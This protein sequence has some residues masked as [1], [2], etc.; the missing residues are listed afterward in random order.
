MSGR[1]SL[2]RQLPGVLV[3]LAVESRGQPAYRLALQTREQYI[4]REKATSNLCTAQVLLAVI[5]SMYAVYHG[6]EGLT[7]I[8]RTVHRRA[9]VLAAGLR[10]LGFALKSEAFFDT[11]TVDVGARKSEIV[12]RAHAEEINLRIGEGTLG[13]ALDETTTP[14]TVEAVWHA[15]GGKLSYAET[16]V[17]ARETLPAALKRDSAFLTHPVFHTH[18]SETELLRYMRKLSDRD[19]ALDR[20]MIPLGSCTMKLN[21]T[22]EMIPLTW[23][24]FGS[25]HPFAPREQ[26]EGYHA[27]FKR[28]EQWL[29][30][31]T[32][33]DAISLQPNSGAQG[34]YA[35]LLAIRA[36]HAARGEPHR[37]VCPIPS[38]AHGTNPASAVMAGMEVVVVGCDARGDVDVDDLRA[39]AEKHSRNLAA[40]MITYPSTHGV[41]A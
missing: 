21:A 4:R 5:A 38:S 22:A 18:R 3:W 16:E 19:L 30:D 35:G 40:V 15:F 29:C 41:F 31:I 37:K 36:Y 39:K 10:K 7:H 33:Y 8:A 24:E 27:L 11:V 9:T 28:L 34:E 13:I 2:T 1:C 23:P 17:T 14:A 12:V 26:A 32:G 20:A 6:P 25:L